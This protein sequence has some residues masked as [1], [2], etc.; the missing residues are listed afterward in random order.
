MNMDP[1][2]SPMGNDHLVFHKKRDEQC[3]R[4]K[5]SW[6]LDCQRVCRDK[7][8]VS[9]QGYSDSSCETKGADGKASKPEGVL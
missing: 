9:P 2:L 4:H 6:G 7:S 1:G 8:K 5:D 3:D